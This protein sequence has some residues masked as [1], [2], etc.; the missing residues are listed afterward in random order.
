MGELE[1]PGDT[2][3]VKKTDT[4]FGR[5]SAI[6]LWY[7]SANHTARYLKQPL[8]CVLVCHWVALL[9]FTHSAGKESVGV[10]NAVQRFSA[11]AVWWEKGCWLTASSSVLSC[12]R[13]KLLSRNGCSRTSCG[14]MRLSGSRSIIFLMRSTKRSWSLWLLLS[15]NINFLRSSRDLSF[16]C[17]LSFARYPVR[18]SKCL[19]LIN[20][21]RDWPLVVSMKKSWV[22][23][24]RSR[25]SSAGCPWVFTIKFRTS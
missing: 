7:V 10:S 3:T 23:C 9:A 18:T 16:M 15:I 4:L 6:Y 22:A 2:L 12:A 5:L 8:W 21:Q 13:V 20:I 11:A 24:P 25:I 14:L 19:G 17:L 1:D